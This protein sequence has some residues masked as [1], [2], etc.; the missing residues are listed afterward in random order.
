MN[1]PPPPPRSN[2]VPQPHFDSH[3]H[4]PLCIFS[5][6]SVCREASSSI[7]PY[8]QA[9]A[10]VIIARV[11]IENP[12]KQHMIFHDDLAKHFVAGL[13]RDK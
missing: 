13:S 2:L 6:S 10:F 1:L 5:E 3:S 11:L 7:V 12:G 8:S 4:G 9:Q